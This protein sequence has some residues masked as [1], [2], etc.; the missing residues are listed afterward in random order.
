MNYIL[1]NK[2]KHMANIQLDGD[3]IE[4]ENIS[5]SFLSMDI[6][7]WVV[8]RFKPSTRANLTKA[9][10]LAEMTSIKE[11][12]SINYGI[13][14][15]DTFWI[16]PCKSKLT[17]EEISPYRNKLCNDISILAISG[18]YNGGNLKSPSPDYTVDGSADKC[19]VRKMAKYTYTKHL[20]N[21]SVV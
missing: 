20:V 10:R 4:I 17:W 14:M 18:I 8:N 13:S 3:K 19:W 12:I 11:Y 5:I 21:V 15:T 6:N 1:L 2:N 9:L 7:S 16:K